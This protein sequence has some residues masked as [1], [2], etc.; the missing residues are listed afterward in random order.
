M[1]EKKGTLGITILGVLA[2]IWGLSMW[3]T[4]LSSLGSGKLASPDNSGIGPQAFL[5]SDNFFINFRFY[6]ICS[7]PIIAAIG[8]LIRKNWGRILYV[9]CA[10]VGFC[11]ILFNTVRA[12]IIFNAGKNEFFLYLGFL[13]FHAIICFLL[14]WFFTRTKVKGQFK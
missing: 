11:Y 14:I 1:M 10:I 3:L 4:G 9:I 6:A 13:L 8:V 2:I 12:T 5:I 7:L